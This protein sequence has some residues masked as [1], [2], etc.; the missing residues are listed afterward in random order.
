ME[1]TWVLTMGHP[2][3]IISIYWIINSAIDT[4]EPIDIIDVQTNDAGSNNRP[5]TC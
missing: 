5:D 2:A 1:L 3:E 4:I